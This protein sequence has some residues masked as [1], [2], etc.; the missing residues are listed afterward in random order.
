[1][2]APPFL[3]QVVHTL[4]YLFSQMLRIKNLALAALAISCLLAIA[5]CGSDSSSSASDTTASAPLTKA[6]FIKRANA[7][8]AKEEE[9]STAGYAAYEK[10]EGIKAGS[11]LTA[12]QVEEIV[13]DYIVPALETQATELHALGIP[14]NQSDEDAVE[15]ILQRLDETIEQTAENPKAFL[16]FSVEPWFQ[17][18]ER[19]K[20]FGLQCGPQ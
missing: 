20:K 2:A 11:E 19:S 1:L 7:I 5:G 4:L 12:A 14:K 13:A 15:L 6:Q 8:C 18:G 10:K 17:F 3:L 16:E 9:V